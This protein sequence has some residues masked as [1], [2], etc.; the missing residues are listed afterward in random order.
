MISMGLIVFQPGTR[1][2]TLTTPTAAAT[3]STET[4]LYSP[5]PG[6]F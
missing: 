5:V 1:T 4:P 6:D 2:F 3:N